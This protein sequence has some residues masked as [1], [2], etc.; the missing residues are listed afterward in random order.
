MA[1]T[2]RADLIEGFADDNAA[3]AKWLGRD[4]SSWSR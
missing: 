1:P 4:L 3:L 2:V